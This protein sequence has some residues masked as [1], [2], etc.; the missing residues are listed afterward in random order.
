MKTLKFIILLLILSCCNN[1]IGQTVNQPHSLRIF[2]DNDFLNFRGSGTDRYYTNGL[3]IDMYYTKKQKAKFPSSLLLHISE[4]NNVYGWGIAQFMFTPK[5]ID[6][7]EIQYDDRPYAGA[8]YSIHSL[9]SFDNIENI[10]I[11]T[12]LFIGVIGPWSLAEESQTWIHGMI[13]YTKP[14]G[15][16]NQV[17]NDLLLN[18]NINIEKQLLYPSRSIL[19]VGVVETYSGTLY[20]AAGIGF[21][22]RIG[23]F[24]NYFEG[25]SNSISTSE[26]RFQLYVF[27][28][29][30]ARVVLSNALLEGGLI[31][32]MTAQTGA[33]TLDK[34]QIER[35]TVLYDVGLN[36][37]MPK[38]SISISQKLRTAEF[39]GQYVQEVGNITLKANL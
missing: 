15:W 24:N 34:D 31:Y 39:K 26:N 1:L 21:L 28:K 9:Q 32:Q 22:L 23:K 38:F 27:M 17:A 11:T 35:L 16:D 12:E 18:Y 36:F 19:L 6:V 14:Q 3:R 37:E 30:V 10:K 25:I 13:D 4:N 2:L 33:Y 8:L 5:H 29:P 7:K 20:N